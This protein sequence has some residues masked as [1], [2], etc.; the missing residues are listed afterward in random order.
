MPPTPHNY[1]MQSVA[2][3]CIVTSAPQPN[4][5]MSRVE[6][7][8]RLPAHVASPITASFWSTCAGTVCIQPHSPTA[9]R[10]HPPTHPSDL[11]P[12]ALILDSNLTDGFRSAD[13][14]T[15]T[16]STSG[17]PEAGSRSPEY[18]LTP[19]ETESILDSKQP[20]LT[21]VKGPHVMVAR[22]GAPGA[23]TAKLGNILNEQALGM[24]ETAVVDSTAKKLSSVSSTNSLRRALSVSRQRL[25]VGARRRASLSASASDLSITQ[26][27]HKVHVFRSEVVGM[28]RKFSSSFQLGLVMCVAEWGGGHVLLVLSITA[29]EPRFAAD[30]VW[31]SYGSGCICQGIPACVHHIRISA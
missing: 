11:E 1:G 18:P 23:A 7:A 25:A 24:L 5:P 17:G 20:G 30:Q 14:A 3:R 12:R 8:S 26:A 15:M 31:P 16:V 19:P 4:L 22:G 27:E 9:A 29:A 28:C 13:A 6:A 2:A 10:T 21:S